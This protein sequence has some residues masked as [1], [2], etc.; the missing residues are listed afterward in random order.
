MVEAR[1]FEPLSLSESNKASTDLV[2]WKFSATLKAV[3]HLTLA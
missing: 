2:D 1:G 3:H